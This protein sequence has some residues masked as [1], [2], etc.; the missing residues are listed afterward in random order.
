MVRDESHAVPLRA[1]H[2][3][4]GLRRPSRPTGGPFRTFTVVAEPRQ[5][6]VLVTTD[7][8]PSVVV[9]DRPNPPLSRADRRHEPDAKDQEQ[10]GL[11][12]SFREPQNAEGRASRPAPPLPA[13]RPA[14]PTEYQELWDIDDLANYLVVPKQTRTTGYGPK[15]FRI[16]KHLRWRAATVISWTLGLEQAQ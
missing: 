6:S 5:Q 14:K 15:G 10:L 4:R 11:W 7:D 8:D 9:S 13:R 12:D 1:R 3:S 16:G 2:V